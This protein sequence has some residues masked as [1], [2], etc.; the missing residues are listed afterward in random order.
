MKCSS[1]LSSSACS[2][3]FPVVFVR[4]ELT[5]KVFRFYVLGFSYYAS[6]TLL[7]PEFY[8]SLLNR[9]W[10]RSGTLLYK[11]DQRASCCPQ[12]T[13][14]LDSETFRA[15]KDQRQTLNRFHKHVLGDFY[16]NESARLYPRSRE[17]AKKRNTDFD[18]LE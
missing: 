1:C 9:G 17:Q 8:Q 10:R 13:I 18:L 14:R 2:A 4:Q 6:T 3:E 15:S 5:Y 11:P 12:Y 7:Q 16:S